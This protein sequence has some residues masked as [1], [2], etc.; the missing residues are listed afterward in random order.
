MD[1]SI[2]PLDYEHIKEV[3]DLSALAFPKAEQWD[4]FS[5][6]GELVKHISH[7]FVA[8]YEDKVIG[9]IG[10]WIIVDEAQINTIVTDPNYRNAGV[11][12]T[13]LNH[14]INYCKDLNVSSI[15][16][17]VRQSNE[18]AKKLYM[19]KGFFI[20]GERKNYYSNNGETALLMRVNLN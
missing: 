8:L 5:L 4:V 9:F 12:T 19:N 6:K 18:I 10:M 11:G 13:L 2:V 3:S 1:I 14:V 17:E 16:L 15:S 20:E 7:S